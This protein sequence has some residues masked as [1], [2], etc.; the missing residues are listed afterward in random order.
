MK[1]FAS[2]RSRLLL[3]GILAL[4]PAMGLVLQSGAQLRE[5]A[6]ANTQE[7]VLRLAR[8]AA[9]NQDALIEGA[10]QTLIV[11]AQ[12]P[13]VR[14]GN[15]SECSRFL[16]ELLTRYAYYTN[17]GVA[18]PNG[19]VL[20]NGLPQTQVANIADRAYFQRAVK[21]REFTTSEYVLGR[22]SGKPTIS[23]AY[24]VLD[25]A[26]QLK[27]IL[28]AGLDLE[29]MNKL[30]QGAMLPSG[31]A[32]TTIDRNGTVLTRFPEPEKYVGKTFADAPIV[33]T[34]LETKTEGTV[35]ALGVDGVDR[36][37]AYLPLG[38]AGDPIAFITVGIPSALGFSNADRVTTRII[39][40]IIVTAVLALGALVIGGEIILLRP[41]R[42][43]THAA[44]RLGKG[45]LSARTDLKYDLAEMGDLARE[46]DQ[47]ASSLEKQQA[48]LRHNA[49]RAQVLAELSQALAEISDDYHSVLNLAARR[50]AELL[51]DACSIRLVAADGVTMQL[52]ADHHIDPDARAFTHQLLT[53]IPQRADENIT[54]QVFRTGEALLVPVVSPAA[55]RAQVKPE[56]HVLLDRLKFHSML[57]APLR[58]EGKIIGVIAMI[59][60]QTPRAYTED[61]KIF[62][63]DLADRAA[64][65]ISKARLFT[66]IRELNT[67]LELRVDE[68][69]AQLGEAKQEAER[70]NRA[71]SDFLA[72]MSH[73]LRTPLN[74]IL[75]FG[76]LL[77]LD[78]DA[79]NSNQQ[80]GIAQI[81][82]A[83]NHLLELINEVL[84]I[85][86]VEAGR[87]SLS[88][89][90]VAILPLAQ[91][92]ADLVRPLAAKRNIALNIEDRIS[93]LIHVNADRQR[94]KQVLLNL[95][96]NAVKYNRDAGAITLAFQ[97]HADNR[98]RVQ[99]RDTGP[100]I[101]PA[102]LPRLF[103]PF[104]RLDADKSKT[105]GT[106]LGLALSKR[107][108]E[109]MGGSI[110]ADS[111]V[112]KG[113]TFWIEFAIVPGQTERAA[114][115]TVTVDLHTR[116]QKTLL[117]VE[118]NLSNLKLVREIL[119][120]RGGFK[121][122]TAMQGSIGI[123][124]AK[125]HRPDL[126]VLDVNLPDMYGDEIVRWLKDDAAT[127]DIPI[128]VLSADS[129]PHQIER[130]KSTGAR[131]YLT[132]PLDVKEFLRVVEEVMG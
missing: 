115:E 80:E 61:D 3:I 102:M 5:E 124:L 120:R 69:T 10:R 14:D 13:Q 62:L 105:E 27:G 118:D 128:I 45:D 21:T 37:Y 89:E 15:A 11:I 113:S 117:Y 46:F 58:V 103:T 73:E 44:Q 72:R 95:L 106:G 32:L 30:A 4:L 121:L 39:F 83:G 20:C 132:K 22:I 88:P 60:D 31:S 107:L 85:A 68:R 55:F 49:V 17:I 64:L 19:D 91:E 25:D 28:I 40:G 6:A 48:L 82:K 59:R 87:M 1:L 86:R 114:R 71:K 8:L 75:G 123:E 130:L 125:E 108:I 98:L 97:T 42:T 52:A 51:G 67:T 101:A 24:P 70:A 74:A 126:I 92:T 96:S 41:M 18:A 50:L 43:L 94:L 81:L 66:E 76:Q 116:P 84:D 47:M 65:A 122:I 33:K 54:A 34:I 35:Q 63:Q 100:G 78:Q 112:G 53:N 104:E 90:P 29:W 111:I 79:F 23:F 99:V 110:G 16:A 127:R 36:L 38:N 77:E 93:E 7:D 2:L 109:A 56:F 129:T 9:S 26:R 131:A 12:T 57:L 119:D